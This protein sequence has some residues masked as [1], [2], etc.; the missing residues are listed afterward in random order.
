VLADAP[1]PVIRER[2]FWP[3][4]FQGEVAMIGIAPAKLF[5]GLT[6]EL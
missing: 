1:V 5:G 3:D 6:D 2:A 4:L